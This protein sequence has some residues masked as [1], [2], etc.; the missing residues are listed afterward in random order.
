MG[1]LTLQDNI[2]E[3]IRA[4]S[5]TATLATT[6]LG[7]PTRITVGGRQYRVSTALT[8]NTGTTGFGGLDTG[9]LSDTH[10]LYYVYAVVQS[11][12]VGLIASLASPTTGPS[13]FTTSYRLVGALYSMDSGNQI[14][15]MITINGE[16]TSEFQRFTPPISNPGNKVFTRNGVWRREG[17]FMR[18]RFDYDGDATASGSATSTLVLGNMPTPYQCDTAKLNR[19][20]SIDLFANRVGQY[21]GSGVHVSASAI[22]NDGAC[23]MFDASRWSFWRSWDGT[24]FATTKLRISDLNVARTVQM[25]GE[26]VIPVLGWSKTLL[27]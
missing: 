26:V 12:V 27:G 5:T 15:S 16:A 6:N 21:S 22:N 19:S 14:G 10:S 18:V 2:P 1:Q 17:Q 4:S 24:G 3:V 9:T 23:T 25:T 13:G 20:D 11:G 7:Q 8:L